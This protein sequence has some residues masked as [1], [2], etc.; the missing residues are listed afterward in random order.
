MKLSN[1]ALR[2]TAKP[3]ST[4]DVSSKNVPLVRR[5]IVDSYDILTA[6]YLSIPGVAL[7]RVIVNI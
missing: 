6:C 3:A 5:L 2:Y 1:F 4:L 7:Q